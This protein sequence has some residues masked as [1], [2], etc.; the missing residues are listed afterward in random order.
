[1]YNKR[2]TT[3][4]PVTSRDYNLGAA[5]REPRFTVSGKFDSTSSSMCGSVSKAY[6]SVRIAN[7]KEGFGTTDSS[8]ERFL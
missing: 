4:I 3:S 2:C 8:V 1:M 6:D 7:L 5:P